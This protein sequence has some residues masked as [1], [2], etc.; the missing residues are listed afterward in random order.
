MAVLEVLGAQEAR[1]GA[2]A[3]V[4]AGPVT[5]SSE[6]VVAAAALLQVQP[7][8]RRVARG[9]LTVL[10]GQAVPAEKEAVLGAVEPPS[11]LHWLS[12]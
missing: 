2:Q 11:K 1:A 12:D 6:E 10:A 9:Y 7:A 4:V 3:A 8:G 5:V